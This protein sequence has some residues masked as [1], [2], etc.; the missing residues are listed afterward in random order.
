MTSASIVSGVTGQQLVERLDS[1][2]Q[3]LS[4]SL[5]VPVSGLAN[6]AERETKNVLAFCSKEG[7]KARK[8]IANSGARIILC[9]PDVVRLLEGTLPDKTLI[10]LD[11]PRLGFALCASVLLDTKPNNS[12]AKD[13]QKVSASAQ[14]DKGVVVGTLATIAHH[15]KIGANTRIDNGVS[16][17]PYT[18]IGARCLIEAGA[19]IGATGFGFER[20]EQGRLHRFPQLGCVV[21]GDQVEIGARVC[22]DRGALQ[23][24]YIGT[25]TKID[26]G[27]YIAHN[28]EIG[29]DCLIM[30]SSVICGSVKIGDK[31]EISPG[32]IVRNGLRIGNNAR[33]GL[34]AVVVKDVEDG[35][36]VAGVP[37]RVIHSNTKAGTKE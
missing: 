19:V 22:I 7:E 18:R 25:G 32:A 26:D 15:C 35:C 27:A 20:D 12:Y 6:L 21:L 24:T 5:D 14:L 31:V 36:L 11:N 3:L 9:L 17:Y 13:G 10:G 2:V 29:Q 34:G 8:L 28:V 16:I 33:I 23:N 37:A 30:A 4:G 1:R